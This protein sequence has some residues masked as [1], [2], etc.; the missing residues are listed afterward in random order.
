MK[1]LPL[2]I[3]SVFLFTACDEETTDPTPD[4]A[5]RDTSP[6]TEASVDQAAKPDLPVADLASV[7]SAST[8]T[9]AKLD[10]VTADKALMDQSAMTDFPPGCNTKI[11]GF[12][13]GN[14][15]KKYELYELCFKAGDTVTEALLKKMDAGLNCKQ[16]SGGVFAKCPSGTWRCLGALK[17]N[18]PAKDITKAHWATICA[19]SWLPSVS[20]IA[21]GHHL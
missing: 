4:A 16:S 7:D 13:Q 5:P 6:Q 21:G 15:A 18:Y 2:L 11:I 14:S 8:D 3:L 1:N 20:K 12:T 9:A 19:M 10:A 17:L